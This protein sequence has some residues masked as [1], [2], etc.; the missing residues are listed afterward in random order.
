MIGLFFRRDATG[1]RRFAC[2]LITA[3]GCALL[4]ALL[5]TTAASA[6][7]PL[8]PSADDGVLGCH[9]ADPCP[10]T[11]EMC[12]APLMCISYAPAMG[13]TYCIPRDDQLCCWAT[14]DCVRGGDVIG[15]C[16]RFATDRAGICVWPD[17]DYC[18]G[19]GNP[20]E[21]AVVN[22]LTAPSGDSVLNFNDG[23]CDGDGHPNGSD[24]CPCEGPT[25]LPVDATG[26][27]MEPDAG[28]PGSDAGPPGG[29]D[30]GGGVIDRPPSDLSG[31]TFRGDG[32]CS[33]WT[34]G[35]ADAPPLGLG[36]GLLL[37]LGLAF[38]R[39]R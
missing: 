2:S 1:R 14:T 6:E 17:F 4:G 20:P 18:A 9:S 7:P 37:G 13:E 31:S 12:P 23:D 30:A 8:V 25:L 16:V 21:S 34:A 27:P 38:R 22:C 29:N 32:G 15:R 39:R 19:G 11:G 35:G 36:L 28:P 26:C 3:S 24:A 5:F 10:D 33:C